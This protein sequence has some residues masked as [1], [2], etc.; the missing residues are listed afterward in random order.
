MT[1]QREDGARAQ[2]RP[3]EIAEMSPEERDQAAQRAVA[4]AHGPRRLRSRRARQPGG[5]DGLARTNLTALTF[6][7]AGLECLYVIQDFGT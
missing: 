5:S 2:P 4:A 7:T 1:E 6:L 3:G